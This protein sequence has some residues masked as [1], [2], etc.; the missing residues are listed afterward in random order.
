MSS[1]SSNSLLSSIGMPGNGMPL[2]TTQRVYS[3]E[4]KLKTRENKEE[5]MKTAKQF[6]GIFIQQMFQ[7]MDKTVDRS[8][9]LF[10]NTQGEQMFRD[11]MYQHMGEGFADRH[12]GSGFGLA[13]AIYKQLETHVKAEAAPSQVVKESTPP[14]SAVSSEDAIKAPV[15]PLS[16][17]PQHQQEVYTQP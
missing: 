3:L 2:D 9:S 6:E 10:G 1:N 15:T 7:A 8:N 14:T 17:L 12:G 5:L 11:M 13:D 16:S 4:H